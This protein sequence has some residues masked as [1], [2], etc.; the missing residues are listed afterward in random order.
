MHMRLYL[1]FFLVLILGACTKDSNPSTKTA[2]GGDT[3]RGK[4]VY[5]TNCAAC[6]N[7]DPS[8]VGPVGPEINGS[9]Q[10][11]LEA[12]LLRASYPP[13]YAPK[14]KSTAMPAQPYLRSTIP[15]LVAFLR[16]P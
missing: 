16:Q 4:A 1:L 8:K 15:D 14:R 2:Q 11:L 3:R 7:R 6:H 5:L 12:K 10:A 9:S 13:G